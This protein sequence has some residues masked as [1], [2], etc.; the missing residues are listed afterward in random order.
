MAFHH[1]AIHDS[2]MAGLQGFRDAELLLDRVHVLRLY[3]ID[4]EPLA[5]HMVYPLHAAV[6]ACAVVDRHFLGAS[7]G[8]RGLVP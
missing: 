3:V 4:G 1:I 5:F 8:G 6:T 7:Q 2:G